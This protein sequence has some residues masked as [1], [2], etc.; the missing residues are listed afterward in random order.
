MDMKTLKKKKKGNEIIDIIS[1][2]EYLTAVAILSELPTEEI[3]SMWDEDEEL[4]QI[5]TD[6]I[7]LYVELLDLKEQLVWAYERGRNK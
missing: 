1:K 5:I 4:A 2:N 6:S 7:S 3:D